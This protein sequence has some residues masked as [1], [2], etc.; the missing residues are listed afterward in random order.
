MQRGGSPT[1]FDRIL[2]SRMGVYAI[3][4]IKQGVTSSCVGI[5]N[6]RLTYTDIDKALAMPRHTS[7]GFV[8]DAVLIA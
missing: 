6:N 1:A 7:E 2:A 4:L 3:N 8:K 5:I